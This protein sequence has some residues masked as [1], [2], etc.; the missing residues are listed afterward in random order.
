MMRTI[1]IWLAMATLGA[2]AC[3][4]K[5]SSDNG[6]ELGAGN[7]T[8]TGDEIG[9]PPDP[10]TDE[11]TDSPMFVPEDLIDG[12]CDPWMQDCPEGEKCVPYSSDGGPWNANKCVPVVGDGQPGDACSYDGIAQATDSCG[13][14]SHCWDVMDVD[15]QLQGVCT[16]FCAGSPDNPICAPETAC[17][18]ANEGSI[19]L[20]VRTCDPLQQDCGAGLG[21]FWANNGFQC[22]FTAGEILAG[23][24]CGYINDCAPGNLCAS[25]DVLPACNS[26]ACCTPYC[27]LADPT[28]GDPATECSAFFEEGTAPPG[29]ESIGVCILPGA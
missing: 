24:P 6:S 1:P 27:D 20:C 13:A 14:D 23:E 7:E 4:G 29:Y 3:E 25:A 18:M 2:S 19:N 11:G 12:I 22:I 10:D 9:D 21:C 15:G 28:C 17:L 26:S 5:P 8:E 16:T